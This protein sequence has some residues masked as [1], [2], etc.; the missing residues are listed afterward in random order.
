MASSR[1]TPAS[2][3]LKDFSGY[4][5]Q[6]FG[7]L[8]VLE[9]VHVERSR[10]DRTRPETMAAFRC[11]CACGTVK[12]VEQPAGRIVTGRTLSCGCINREKIAAR[13][14]QKALDLTGRRFGR[15]VAFRLDLT[16]GKPVYR[17]WLCRCDCGRTVHV[18]Q[19]PLVTG[20]S[21][22]CGCLQ[23][24]RASQGNLT[25]GKTARYQWPVEY[26]SWA[27]IV[28]RCTNPDREGFHNYGG[29]GI[30]VCMGNRDFGHFLSVVGPKASPELSIDR[31]NND[32]HYSCGCCPQCEENWWQ[33]NIRWATRTQQGGNRRTTRP[34]VQTRGLA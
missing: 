14:A 15:L 4:V 32:L 25:H 10:P 18:P 22:S 27:E 26:T 8:T 12:L 30:L 31:I 28:R 29:R 6:T 21:E 23:R 3:R 34:R 9:V 16:H 7:R 33:R 11:R 5:G 24:E 20:H 13:M 2:H 1:S 17:Y 19:R